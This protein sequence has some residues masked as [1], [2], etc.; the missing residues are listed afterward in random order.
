MNLKNEVMRGFSGFAFAVDQ[1]KPEIFLAT[2]IVLIVG[3]GI[4]ACKS[5]LKAHDILEKHAKEMEDI[6]TIESGDEF[7]AEEKAMV[8]KLK[9]NQC[10]RT[11]AE[12]VKMYAPSVIVTGLGIC[13]IIHSH[14][15]MKER[16]T[17]AMAAASVANAALLEY[18][19]RVK[20]EVGDEVEQ[21]IFDGGHKEKVKEKNEKGKEKEVEK[22][23]YD[24][25]PLDGGYQIL[26]DERSD[27]FRKTEVDDEGNIIYGSAANR[28]TVKS[29]LDWANGT[30]DRRGY[31]SLEEV[32]RMLGFESLILDWKKNDPDSFFFVKNYGWTK[33]P[34]CE[35]T[36][37][38]DFGLYSPRL[39]DFGTPGCDTAWLTMNIDKEPLY[40]S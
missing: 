16:N 15:I 22:V 19:D 31:V 30:L 3:G 10:I 28:Q 24:N 1:K 33:R 37:V 26:F 25:K 39:A 21:M 35:P 38:I 12:F 14:G 23:V 18:R 34:E 8:P 4:H 11:T 6:R 40:K 36:K 27:W 20:R 2:G 13:M 5:T 7:S 17:A 32:L 9:T 29:A